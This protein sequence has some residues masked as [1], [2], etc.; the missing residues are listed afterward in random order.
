MSIRKLAG[1]T[2]IYGLSS[3][4]GR[5]A[6]FLLVPLYTWILVDAEFGDIAYFYALMGFLKVLYTL[7]LDTAFFRFGQD[8]AQRPAA[9]AAILRTGLLL[10]GSQ[11][12]IDPPH[13]NGCPAA[14]YMAKC[15]K[16]KKCIDNIKP[17]DVIELID[18][19]REAR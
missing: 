17:N 9:F 11:F 3:I 12:A 2:L 1:E 6:N 18:R 8:P 19:I 16:E 13:R 10:E 4:L 5:F 15:L 14:C 7:Q